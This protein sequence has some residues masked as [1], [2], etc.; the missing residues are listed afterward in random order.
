M[1]YS[2]EIDD[3][4]NY[5][6]VGPSAGQSSYWDSRTVRLMSHLHFAAVKEARIL[7]AQT[8]V[9]LGLYIPGGTTRTSR[10]T[11]LM[12]FRQIR[13]LMFFCE[14]IDG[15]QSSKTVHILAFV[16]IGL[17]CVGIATGTYSLASR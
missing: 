8:S 10:S 2:A 3:C 5:N 13:T 16:W 15:F 6:S 7:M 14:H 12:A 11:I 1:I 17:L 4:N 9:P